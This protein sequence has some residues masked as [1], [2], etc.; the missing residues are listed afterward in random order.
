MKKIVYLFIFAASLL[1][2]P[3]ETFAGHAG[4]GKFKET[5]SDSEYCKKWPSSSECAGTLPYCQKWPSSSECAG[6]QPYCE[7]WPNSSECRPSGDL[8][9]NNPNHPSCKNK[10]HH[11]GGGSS[12]HTEP[13]V[14]AIP[15]TAPSS[16]SNSL[17]CAD[18]HDV[19]AVMCRADAAMARARCV[20]SGNTNCP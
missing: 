12:G 18:G 6:T 20:M 16:P 13:A 1:V 7:K 5:P 4:K 14:G 10:P 3:A 19:D 2:A 17:G 15:D 8:C 11:S 9:E